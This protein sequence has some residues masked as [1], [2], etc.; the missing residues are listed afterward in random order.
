METPCI[1]VCS[2]DPQNG[3]CIGCYRTIDE[4]MAWSRYTD[5]Q[6]HKIMGELAGRSDRQ[7]LETTQETAN[8]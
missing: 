7:H 2:L 8:V 5:A 6:R 4:I 3:L 1:D